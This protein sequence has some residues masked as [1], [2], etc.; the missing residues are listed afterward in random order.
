MKQTR[1]CDT[2]G[3]TYEK[4]TVFHH[5]ELP[6]VEHGA[7]SDVIDH[8]FQPEPVELNCVHCGNKKATRRV[9]PT[10]VG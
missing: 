6:L 9:R 3:D 5:L 4:T 10:R 2:C 1:I 8:Y 7:L